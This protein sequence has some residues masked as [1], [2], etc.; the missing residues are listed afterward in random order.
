MIVSAAA[1][2]TSGGGTITFHPFCQSTHV[3]GNAGLGAAFLRR[4]GYVVTDLPEAEVC[5]GFGGSTSIEHGAVSHGIVSR[6]LDNVR[7]TQAAVLTTDN[8]GCLL[9]LRGAANAAGVRLTIAHPVEL[10]ARRL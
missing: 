9:H 2:G 8:P 4:A 1:S 3:L 10:V 7:T 6:K 5:C